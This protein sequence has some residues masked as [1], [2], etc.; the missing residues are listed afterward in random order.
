M[1][2][3]GK[4]A[5]VAV[6]RT[7]HTSIQCSICMRGPIDACT[8]L[9]MH[10]QCNRCICNTYGSMHGKCARVQ[11]SYTWCNTCRPG[12]WY[13]SRLSHRRWSNITVNSCC[14]QESLGRKGHEESG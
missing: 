4:H 13:I 12:W 14:L 8:V 1:S 6:D 11:C 5:L 2:P 3:S 9:Y 7:A 10:T